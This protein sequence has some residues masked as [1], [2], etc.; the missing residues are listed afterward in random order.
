[1]TGKTLPWSKGE[2]TLEPVASAE[3][4]G[5]CLAAEHLESTTYVAI[6]RAY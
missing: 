3:K 5:K 1:M 6:R 2:K 4:R